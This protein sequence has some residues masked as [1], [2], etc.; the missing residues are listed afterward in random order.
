[1]P[2]ATVASRCSGSS[3]ADWTSPVTNRL[4]LEASGIHRVERWGNMHLQT[5]KG[6]NI[7]G[8][9]PGITGSSTTRRSRP[10][11][12]LNYR[13]SSATFNNSWNWNLHYRFAV[14]Y[15][16][17]SHNFKVGFNNAYLHHENTTYTNPA[18]EYYFNFANGVPS[19]VVYR[20]P[21][22]VAFERRLRHGALRAGPLDR[23]PLDAGGWHP[24]RRLQEPLPRVVDLAD[25]PC[26]EPQRVVPEDRQP[27]AGRTSRRSWVPPTTCSAT[28]RR[29]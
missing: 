19:Q 7:D 14:S 27:R 15:I 18:T 11:A 4:L 21:R 1:M 12:S 22:T 6:D 9:A 5:G 25:V 3:S 8:L 26:T 20:I 16:T 13:A 28:A 24:I 29:R 10:G 2:Q 23:G 17:G